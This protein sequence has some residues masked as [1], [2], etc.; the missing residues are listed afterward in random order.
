M[1]VELIAMRLNGFAIPGSPLDLG[2]FIDP[3]RSG[4][5]KT[6]GKPYSFTFLRDSRKYPIHL[7]ASELR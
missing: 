4:K 6:V 5:Q 7:V 2:T 1:K 3:S